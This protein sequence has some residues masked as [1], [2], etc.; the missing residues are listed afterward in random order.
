MIMYVFEI[1]E[2]RGDIVGRFR[3]RDKGVSD[4]QMSSR[5]NVEY[6]HVTYTLFDETLLQI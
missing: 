3:L 4:V 1:I 5:V 2:S 6:C